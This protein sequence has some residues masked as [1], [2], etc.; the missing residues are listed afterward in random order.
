MKHEQQNYINVPSEVRA[1]ATA[2]IQGESI[3]VAHEFDG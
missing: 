1:I 3:V 2:A